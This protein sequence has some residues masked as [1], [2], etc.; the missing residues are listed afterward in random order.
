MAYKLKKLNKK[1]LAFIDYYLESYNGQESAIKAGFK[2]KQ[3]ASVAWQ[4]RKEPMIE[5]EI[6]RRWREMMIE[7]GISKEYLIDRLLLVM[8][9]SEQRDKNG[10]MNLPIMLKTIDMMA[11]LGGYFNETNQVNIQNNISDNKITVEIVKAK[12]ELPEGTEDI[13]YIDED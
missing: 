4:L 6:Q 13:D 12:V 5:A 10:N 1:H 2:G 9:E 7:R 8:D 11:K 3:M